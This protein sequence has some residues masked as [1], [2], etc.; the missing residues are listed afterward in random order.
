MKSPN[1]GTLVMAIF[2]FGVLMR[3]RVLMRAQGGLEQTGI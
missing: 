1:I 3:V 2:F